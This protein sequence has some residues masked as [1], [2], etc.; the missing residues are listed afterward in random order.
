MEWLKENHKSS[1]ISNHFDN[2]FEI[3]ESCSDILTRNGCQISDRILA[4]IS[5]KQDQRAHSISQPK[6]ENQCNLHRVFASGLLASGK[7]VLDTEFKEPGIL[8]HKFFERLQFKLRD[9]YEEVK[10][11]DEIDNPSKFCPFQNL[12][13]YERD[14][15][16]NIKKAVLIALQVTTAYLGMLERLYQTPLGKAKFRALI[17]YAWDFIRDLFT[18]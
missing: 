6:A 1:I 16:C 17:Y 9:K 13:Q 18:Q 8:V 12:D 15:I 4:K 11:S 2:H 5:T 14:Y 7:I 3:F 10:S